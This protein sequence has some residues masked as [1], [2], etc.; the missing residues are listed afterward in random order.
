MLGA[1]ILVNRKSDVPLY[2][3]LVSSVRDAILSGRLEAGE[4][5]LSSRDL[6]R[7]LGLSRNTIVE[8]LAQLHAEGYLIT[9]RGVGT[10]VSDWVDRK[11]ASLESLPPIAVKT[12]ASIDAYVAAAPLTARL[13]DAVP[14][15]PG[16]PALDLFPASAFK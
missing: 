5:L 3:Q 10:F 6:Q 9:V 16:V 8:A 11:N 14:F 12:S 13:G 7:H 15:R 2:R 1:G 4:R